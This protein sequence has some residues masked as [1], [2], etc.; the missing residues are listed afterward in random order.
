MSQIRAL[1]NLNTAVTGLMGEN[2]GITETG[3]TA[4]TGDFSAIQCL[5]DTVFSTLTRPDFTGD[6]LTGVTLTAGTI[7]Y[8]KCTA[9]TLTSGKVIAYNRTTEMR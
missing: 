2:G 5:E 9:F 4:V 8:G 3:T 1:G 7:L 6:A